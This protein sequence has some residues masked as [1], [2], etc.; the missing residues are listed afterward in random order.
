MESMINMH[1]V[2][3]S[4]VYSIIGIIILVLSF[5]IVEKITP[6]NLYKKIVEENNIAIAIVGA[7]FILAIAVII[8]SAIRG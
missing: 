1:G 7:G 4:V 3:S 6:H 8:S 5:Y 2:V